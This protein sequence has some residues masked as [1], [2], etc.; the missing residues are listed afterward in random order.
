M[1]GIRGYK[2]YL[3]IAKVKI[4]SGKYFI[5]AFR[6]LKKP[7]VWRYSNI[8]IAERKTAKKSYTA[9]VDIN[10]RY[11]PTVV[12]AKYFHAAFLEDLRYTSAFR[13]D[14]WG[15]RGLLLSSGPRKKR[16]PR[17]SPFCLPLLDH[18]PLG[19]KVTTS[20]SSVFIPLPQ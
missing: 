4:C 19:S 15:A 1:L 16:A 6:H 8:L 2:R 17:R 9:H 10:K 12:I 3:D 18:S 11:S 7:R 14:S 5:R 20:V 13:R